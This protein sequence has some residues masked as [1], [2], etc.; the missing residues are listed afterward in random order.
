MILYNL[1]CADGHEF[2]GWFGN[3]AAFDRQVRAKAVECPFCGSAK[4]EKALM[5]PRI[6]KG[7][8]APKAEAPAKPAPDQAKMAEMMKTLREA[9]RLVEENFDYVGPGFAEEARK[10]HYGETEKKAI[11]GESSEEDAKALA[12]EGIE[13]GRMP[14][15]PRADN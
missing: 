1:R 2:E 3:S 14:W 8:K 5:A 4:V 11:Y 6:G 13:F 15:V 9:R 12:E 10:I 7:A